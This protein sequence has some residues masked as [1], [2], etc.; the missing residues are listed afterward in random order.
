MNYQWESENPEFKN[1]IETLLQGQ[2]FMHLVG[3]S[4][5]EVSEGKVSAQ[6]CMSEKHQQQNGFLHGGVTATLADIVSGLAALTLVS[7]EVHVVTADLNVS[8]LY[9]AVG[10]MIEAVGWVYKKG[11]NLNYCE[12]E[13]YAITQESRV[14]VAKSRSI[15]ANVF[16]A[17]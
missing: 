16:P 9:P 7:K 2:H 17:S 8:Y 3:I 10:Q 1:R 14:L 11:K 5:N 15:M 12:A 4:I 13:V 6:L